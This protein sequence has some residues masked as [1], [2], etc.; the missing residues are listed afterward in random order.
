[1][2]KT[3]KRVLL[4]TAVFLI[5]V[6]AAVVT[7]IYQNRGR[8][9][10]GTL[11]AASYPLIRLIY[12]GDN[13]HELH[14][15][16]EKM[17]PVSVRDSITPL[18][19]DR[20]LTMRIETYGQQ[21]RSVSYQIR[22]LDGSH[23]IED[24]Q[25]ASFQQQENE[26][27]ANLQIS[28]LIE[29]NKEYIL[30]VEVD[31]DSRPIYYYSRIIY[32]ESM[33]TTELLNFVKE[34]SNATF[35][36]GLAAD[37]GIANYL[38]T[39]SSIG[40]SD[41]SYTNI[42]STRAMVTWGD[43]KPQRVGEVNAKITE[44]SDTQMSVVLT[45]Q[46]QSQDDE[47]LLYDVDEFFCVRYR[48]DRVYLLDY[49]R[50][51]NQEFS[52]SQSAMENGNLLL[53]VTGQDCQVEQVEGETDKTVKLVAFAYDGQLWT[54]QPEK[55]E[56]K[57]IFSFQEEEDSDV[58]HRYKEYE[59][60]IVHAA[61]NGNV[62]FMVYGYMNR[63]DHEGRVGISFYRYI[64]EEGSL[65][66]KFFIPVT[67]SSQMLRADLGELTYVNQSDMCYF[68]Y[69]NSIYS[70][71]L[72]SGECVEV[73]NRAQK[74]MYAKNDRENL[75]AWQDGEDE[76]FPDR[77]QVL[78][79][80]S[81]EITSIT[82]AEGEYVKLEDFIQNDLVYGIGRIS[83]AVTESGMV[84]AYPMY[85]L[86]IVDADNQMAVETHYEVAGIHIMDAQVSESQISM[87]RAI[88]GADGTYQD[89]NDDMLLLNY[90]DEDD[91]AE[92][93][94]TRTSDTRK[95][96]YYL[97]L[98]IEESAGISVTAQIPPIR[99]QGDSRQI[100][101]PDSQ[102]A[103]AGYYV[104]AKGGLM[105]RE[106][107]LSSAISTAYDNMGVVVDASQNYL[108]TRDTRDVYKTLGVGLEEADSNEE[109]LAAALRMIIQY[110]GGGQV[111]TAS[112]LASQ[113]SAYQILSE[114]L[115]EQIILD[116]QG[117]TVPHLLYYINENHPVLALTGDG[118]ARVILGY[119]SSNVTIYDPFG[120]QTYTMSQDEATQSFAAFGSRFISCVTP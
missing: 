84:T 85:A 13:Y 93:V 64:E 69:G 116:L 105:A 15:Y 106:G 81:G 107:N 5:V 38:Q 8:E 96:E 22:S 80:D 79:M 82:A 118:S 51:V 90:R 70:V 33:Y 2:K 99:R 114:A 50:N 109:S 103:A 17:D 58:R 72:T 10:Q 83:D 19:E 65:E 77:I 100:T 16:T 30:M 46:I 98:G 28:N 21:I 113:K 92:F 43:W 53:G 56:M 102:S 71:D 18:N 31:T 11:Q 24:T 94:T 27:T 67:V 76:N 95:R 1:M 29:E 97:N 75:V 26:M 110:E 52:V 117:C 42:H 4:L 54:Y 39:D 14:G 68:L 60:Q 63:G 74:G 115:P 36:S 34:F 87:K 119:D 55:N 35:D 101:L 88:K 32:G 45:Y 59:I 73:T 37:F 57:Q 120:N 66:E 23:L 86:E 41:Y 40:A 3:F 89:T 104:Y 108:W 9:S 49:A 112:A 6:I 44:L 91:A 7:A 62:D 78:N 25:V 61:E 20:T 47:I 12:E 48:N 111:D